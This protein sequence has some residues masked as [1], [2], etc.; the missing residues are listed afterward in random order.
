MPTQLT[1]RNTTHRHTDLEW[2]LE[3]ETEG[4]SNGLSPELV[5]SLSRLFDEQESNERVKLA[6]ELSASDDTGLSQML[7]ARELPELGQRLHYY[8]EVRALTEKRTGQSGY[9]TLA[10][11]L[12]VAAILE[13]APLLWQNGDRNESV[14]LLNQVEVEDEWQYSQVQLEQYQS[15]LIAYHLCLGEDENT[16]A[17]LALDAV[18]S[19]QWYY[20]NALIRFRQ[21]GDTADTRGALALAVNEDIWIGTCLA[22]LET[23]DQTD[24]IEQEDIDYVNVTREAWQAT[25]GAVAWLKRQLDS[26]EPLVGETDDLDAVR[27]KRLSNNIETATWHVDRD[28]V[29]SAKRYFNTALKEAEQLTDGGL[30]FTAIF[31]ML[32]QLEELTESA[33][34]YDSARLIKFIDKL[35]KEHSDASQDRWFRTYTMFAEALLGHH[36]YQ[37]AEDYALKALAAWSRS[38]EQDPFALNSFDYLLALQTLLSALFAKV[39]YEQVYERSTEKSDILERVVGPKHLDLVEP[40]LQ[41]RMSLHMME[42]HE[43]EKAILDRILAIDVNGHKDEDYEYECEHDARTRLQYEE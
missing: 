39:S 21:Y 1:T 2:L 43:E 13:L 23:E 38:Q 28:D 34:S 22:E 35:E 20:L 33:Q 15:T 40:L 14:A 25:D 29:K 32:A 42:R 19:A 7:L 6:K 11:R 41:S 24:G 12:D 27:E 17:I 10:S 30:A 18:P 36:S 26:E 5:N 3:L 4:P 8:Q 31:R 16:H 37:E 9:S